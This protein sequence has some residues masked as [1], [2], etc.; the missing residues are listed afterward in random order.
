MYSTHHRFSHFYW[1]TSL[2]VI[3]AILAGA[4]LIA[5]GVAGRVDNLAAWWIAAG[6]LLVGFAL[7]SLAVV[8]MMIKLV[9][10]AMR[11]LDVL[12]DVS[13]ALAEQS[14]RLAVLVA[15]SEISDAAKSLVHRG[16]ELDS[17]REAIRTD[18]RREDWDGA[19]HLIT[20]MEERF[21]YRQEASEFRQEVSNSRQAAIERKLKDAVS[22]IERHFE[23]HELE[24]AQREI[25][26]VMR[27]LPDDPRVSGLPKR[28]Q[29]L[30]EQRKQELMR[31]WSGAVERHD[32]DHAI[33]VLRDLDAYLTA[34]EA[35]SL[36]ESARGIFKEKL[37]QLG[38]RFR[39]AVTEKRWR[40]ALDI[41]AEI[42]REFPN[43]R[44]AQE[45][46]DKL[47]ILRERAQTV[48]AKAS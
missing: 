22:Q 16:R 32:V 40:D 14:A 48:E 15:N 41:G 47:D 39:F 7:L 31:A 37:M 36:E 43:A 35:R 5:L 26:R 28:L 20:Q 29:A 2:F 30:R 1:L 46:R 23:N 10:I 3:V 21:G 44:M 19:G 9:S 11:Q 17:L 24:Q 12:R 42:I 8:A 13:D 38:V 45:V 18:I 33:E 34:E 25:E 4:G 6:I 27:A